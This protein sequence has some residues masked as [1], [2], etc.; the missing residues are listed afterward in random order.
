MGNLMTWGIPVKDTHLLTGK[1]GFKM[2]LSKLNEIKDEE[3][4]K[5][6]EGEDDKDEEGEDN[7]DEES[8][9]G[10][11]GLSAAQKNLPDGL[12][13]AIAAKKGKK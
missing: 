9:E 13:K 12:Q 7:K 4:D 10:D 3:D 1:W 6:E 2:N 8:D 5:D 11:N